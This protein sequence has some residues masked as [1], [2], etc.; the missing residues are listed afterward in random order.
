L[1]KNFLRQRR[2]KRVFL[3]AKLDGIGRVVLNGIH[4]EVDFEYLGYL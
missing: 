4:L 3:Y 1:K 2:V